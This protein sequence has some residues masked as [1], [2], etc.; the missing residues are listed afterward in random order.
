METYIPAALL[1][2]KLEIN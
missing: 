2:N 1:T